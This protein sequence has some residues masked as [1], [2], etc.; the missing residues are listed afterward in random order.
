MITARWQYDDAVN[1]V[2]NPEIVNYCNGHKYDIDLC[3]CATNKVA[4]L[5]LNTLKPIY[6]TTKG[7]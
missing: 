1:K 4:L 2:T 3:S 7:E 5:D 6:F